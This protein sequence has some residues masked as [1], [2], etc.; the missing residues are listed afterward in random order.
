MVGCYR[1]TGLRTPSLDRL[2]A[3]G[4]RFERAY[5]TQPVCQPARAAL[6][7]GQ[8]PHSCGSWSN[9]MGIADNTRTVG[10]RLMDQGIH[11]A[12]IGKWHLDGGD[13]FGLGQ[14]A[15]GWD[16]AYWYDMRNYLEELTPEQRILSRQKSTMSE[17]GVAPE[18]TF[19]HRCADRARA[20]LEKHAKEDFF[21]VVSFDEPHDPFLCPEPYASM[22]KDYVFPCSANAND[23]L[24]GKPAHQ[25][26][27]AQACGDEIGNF[28]AQY[29]FGCNSFVDME[30]GRIIDQIE[31]FAPDALI[32]YTS[33]HGEM[34]GSH[35]LMEKG[36][37]A[38]DEIT[39]IPFIAKGPGISAGKVSSMPLSHISVAPTIMEWFNCPVPS[40][41]DGQS[42][43]PVLQGAP[44]YSNTVFIE[45]GRFEVD[46][47]GF[48]GLQLMRAAFDGRYKLVINLL[49]TDELYDLQ[50]DPGELK[51]LIEDDQC[52]EV[53]D[54]LHDRILAEMYRTRDPFRGYY[55]R[56]RPWR[57]SVSPLTWHDTGLTRQRDDQPYEKRQLE[58]YT[59]LAIEQTV[60]KI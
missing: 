40:V 6:F 4:I 53:R 18:F 45:F 2:A 44:E 34:L 13:Y 43:L 22:Y 50:D 42:I 11:T 21:L 33:D 58:Y 56:D 24:Q 28:P 8:Y 54:C 17:G 26:I 60:R 27:W 3:Q 19:A 16:P 31:T 59:G 20:F 30:I 32:L 15:D 47:D 55:W 49:A 23:D 46:H 7:T 36:P 1:D 5:C 52:A 29:F 41:F 25:K 51:N 9:A 39:R 37:N 10:R 35:G 14:A 38:Y 48:G 57:K 12:Y